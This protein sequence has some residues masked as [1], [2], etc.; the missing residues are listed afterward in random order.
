M[1]IQN[2]LHRYLD[3]PGAL[4]VLTALLLAIAS[5]ASNVPDMTRPLLI[6]ALY[7]VVALVGIIAR[8]RNMQRYSPVEAAQVLAGLHALALLILAGDNPVYSLAIVGLSLMTPAA[9]GLNHTLRVAGLPLLGA[10]AGVI[11]GTPSAGFIILLIGLPASA[12]L[13]RVLYVHPVAAP[14]ASDSASET[15]SA[16][17][18]TDTA[19]LVA[20]TDTMETEG[21]AAPASSAEHFAEIATRMAVTVDGLVRSIEAIN[22][23]TSQQTSGANEQARVIKLANMLLEDFLQLSERIMTEARAMTSAA[24][25]AAD[26]SSS[27]QLTIQEAIDGMDAI[28]SQVGAIGETIVKLAQ[29]TRRIDEIITSV[30]E[31]ATQS[32]LLALNASIEAAR[33]GTHGRGFAVVADEVRTL[34]QQST[35]AATQVRAILVQIQAAM[36][37]TI[38]ATESGMEEVDSGVAKTR[39]A[40][41]VMVQLTDNINESYGAIN[42][43]YE[44]IRQQ[45]N[46]L[47]EMAISI[48]RID[49]ITQQNLT[50][51]QTVETVSNNLERLAADLQATMQSGVES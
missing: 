38:S 25:Q 21:Y 17:V 42:A 36:K 6:A 19:E 12:L 48:D 11:I 29:L 26:I 16:P 33:A 9:M 40:N 4:A 7:A 13:Y 51:A 44:I 34:A 39:Q 3:P 28:R 50:S 5:L 18:S 23:V 14:P 41:S 47:E 15:V 45:A 2:T 35:Q 8:W 49:R 31:I 46:G 30:S 37:D 24:Q 10:I 32:N 20:V 43:I 1:T 22:D 27:G